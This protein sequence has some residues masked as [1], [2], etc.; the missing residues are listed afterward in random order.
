MD[1]NAI[2]LELQKKHD[3]ELEFLVKW[4]QDELDRRDDEEGSGLVPDID[5]GEETDF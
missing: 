1:M 2:K 3:Q 4:I 5:D